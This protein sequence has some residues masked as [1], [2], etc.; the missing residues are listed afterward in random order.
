MNAF[1][2]LTMY[3]ASDK[4]LVDNEISRYKVGSDTQGLKVAE[5]GSIT[6]PISHK[7]PRERMPP[8]GY[9]HPKA[10]ST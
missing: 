4:M 2:S 8:T 3:D 5:N 10:V 9:R 1:W 7:S 6:I